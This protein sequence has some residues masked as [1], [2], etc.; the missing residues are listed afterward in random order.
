MVE[1]NFV[2]TSDCSDVSVET[3]TEDFTY[4]DYMS[5]NLTKDFS[6]IAKYTISYSINNCVEAELTE[7]DIA[8]NYDLQIEIV[9]CRDAD[10]Q[11]SEYLVKLTGINPVLVADMRQCI[12]GGGPC[13]L[14][15]HTVYADRIEYIMF[16]RL[17]GSPSLDY[18]LTTTEG[19]EYIMSYDIVGQTGDNTCDGTIDYDSYSI[20]YTLPTYLQTPT[21]QLNLNDLLGLANLDPANYFVKICETNYLGTETCISNTMFIDCYSAD[22]EPVE[23]CDS[24][25]E[26]CN[27][28]LAVTSKHKSII[29][30]LQCCKQVD[31][32]I[33]KHYIRKVCPDVLK[34]IN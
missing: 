12:T 4:I 18:K 6:N 34:C 26:P 19:F 23:I 13:L 16:P 24:T 9:S 2:N 21:S 10:E 20:A 17:P 5:K 25:T 27:V 33:I 30:G 8:P 11:G 7:V 1:L 28:V 22:C 32:N 31:L 29:Y 3:P 15:P 14:T